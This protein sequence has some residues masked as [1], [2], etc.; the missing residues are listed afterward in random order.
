MLN[1]KLSKHLA[2]SGFLLTEQTRTCQVIR[3][4]K[5]LCS[6]NGV[7]LARWIQ[8][9]WTV[10]SL[11][12]Q[13]TDHASFLVPRFVAIE[14]VRAGRG[15]CGESFGSRL[16]RIDRQLDIPLIEHPG[17]LDATGVL[18]GQVDRLP[19]RSVDDVRIVLEFGRRHVDIQC[20]APTAAASTAAR[21][22]RQSQQRYSRDEKD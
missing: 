5:S 17:V 6:N 2:R 22:K 18:H 12:D 9:G 19:R 11:D 7:N 13:L 8:L 3:F 1:L 16:T 4:G 14:L 20:R 15:G 21:G 10:A